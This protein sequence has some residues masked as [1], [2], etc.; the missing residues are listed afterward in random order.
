MATLVFLAMLALNCLTPY[1]ADDYTFSFS[2]AT[3]ER[4]TGLWSVLQ[5]QWYHY[6][7]WSGRFLIKCLAQGFTVL[8]KIVFNLLNAA[9]YAGLGLV[10]HRLAI[11]RKRHFEPAVL[12]LIYLS[13][14][15]IAPVF[16]QT[17]L[18]MC[19]SVN[20][21]WATFF[22]M[23]A[24][25]PYALY[26]NRPFPRAAGWRRFAFWRG[27]LPA[28]PAKTP[29]PGCWWRWCCVSASSSGVTKKLPS[30]PGLALRERCWGSRC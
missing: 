23:A 24:L 13:L 17:N 20:Y 9:V 10:L 21:L 2:Y 6:F 28:G 7:H 18:W 25:I 22:C 19:G 8:P 30:G 14:W 27:S 3:G 11:A 4:L 16:G 29:A 15:M 26:L 12:A 1:V 5:S